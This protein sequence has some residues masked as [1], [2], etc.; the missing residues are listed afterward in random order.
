MSLEQMLSL[1]TF[2][3]ME[4]LDNW[5]GIWSTLEGEDIQLEEDWKWAGSWAFCSWPQYSDTLRPHF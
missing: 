1:S 4:W 3:W 2:M 5:T